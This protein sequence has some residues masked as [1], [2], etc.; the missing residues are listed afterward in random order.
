MDLIEQ[1]LKDELQ[2]EKASA[3]SNHS[4]ESNGILNE[5]TSANEAQEDSEALKYVLIEKLENKKKELVCCMS[6]ITTAFYAC[7]IIWTADTLIHL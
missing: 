7:L 3:D 6:T 4:G 1:N 2:Q 5:S